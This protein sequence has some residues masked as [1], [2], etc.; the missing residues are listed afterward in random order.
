MT[1]DQGI[2]V[3]AVDDKLYKNPV[4]RGPEFYINFQEMEVPSIVIQITKKMKDKESTRRVATKRLRESRIK[5][6][7]NGD[8]VIDSFPHLHGDKLVDGVA[9]PFRLQSKIPIPQEYEAVV[10]YPS[11]NCRFIAWDLPFPYATL[12]YFVKNKKLDNFLMKF[13]I[14]KTSANEGDIDAMTARIVSQYPDLL[15]N[16]IK[17]Q[18]QQLMVHRPNGS[19]ELTLENF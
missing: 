10:F 8:G 5:A 12:Y 1:P 13:L 17:Y 2:F 18:D 16:H 4:I 19:F 11:I 7:I 6:K 14:G 15:V 9:W 3:Q